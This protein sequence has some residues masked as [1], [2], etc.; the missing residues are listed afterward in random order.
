MP[1]FDIERW[2]A[3]IDIRSTCFELAWVV[4]NEHK[5]TRR[6]HVCDWTNEIGLQN[7]AVTTNIILPTGIL[8]VFS[9]KFWYKL[10]K[11]LFTI[12]YK[13]F[14]SLCGNT[15]V[16]KSFNQVKISKL[17]IDMKNY[18]FYYFPCF[19]GNQ[20]AYTLDE[21]HAWFHLNAATPTTR[22]T[23]Q[24]KIPKKTYL[25]IIG[26][27]PSHGTFSSLRVRGL[28]RTVTTDWC[29]KKRS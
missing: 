4:F 21:C 6:V 10:Y 8:S 23:E 12:K 9:P 11:Q 19:N 26:F 22:K 1:Y 25:F 20:I 7:G 2:L 27:E 24:A 5:Q 13:N 18:I 16:N 14:H 28:N 17:V 15:H 29:K 3:M